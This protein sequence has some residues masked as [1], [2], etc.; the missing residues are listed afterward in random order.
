MIVVVPVDAPIF[1]EVADPPM[2]TV[3]TEVLKILAVAPA[4]EFAIVGDDP[5]KFTTPVTDK[6]LLICVGADIVGVAVIVTVSVEAS[7]SVV[8]PVTERVVKVE[9]PDTV[10]VVKSA[11]P[12]RYKF[13][14]FLVNEPI[15]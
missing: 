5:V 2:F 7:P 4:V 1:T 13:L 6:V 15:S 3:G 10:A 12:A 9:V 14:H 11:V 8:F